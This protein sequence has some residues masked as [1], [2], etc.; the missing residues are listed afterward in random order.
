MP[1]AAAVPVRFRKWDNIGDEKP[2]KGRGGMARSGNDRFDEVVEALRRGEAA[3]FPTDTVCGVGVSVRD[4]QG[5][6]ELFR[7]KR[8]PSGKPVAWLVGGVS[9]L[10][11]FGEDVPAAAREAAGKAWPGA[12]TLVVKA[13]AKV[14]RAFQSETGTI[15]L[16]MPAR[17]SALL[18]IR[19]VGCPL[20]TTS[21]N[22]SGDAAPR[23]LKDADAAFLAQVDAVLPDDG[24]SDDPSDAE[25]SA[26]SGIASTVLDCTCDPPRVL[27]QGAVRLDD[28]KLY[29]QAP[30]NAEAF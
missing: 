4:A 8:R 20:A 15:G 19:A 13:S 3:V 22:F 26:S 9:D 23:S 17:E 11:R 10:D 29:S 25:P 24:A 16:R 27:R 21:A 7:L 30:Y 2:L 6:D 12:L 18:L 5:P 1:D 14:P 28:L